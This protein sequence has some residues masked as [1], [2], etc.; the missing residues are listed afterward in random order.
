MAWKY[1]A[2]AWGAR[3]SI[4]TQA[5]DEL[6]GHVDALALTA[7]NAALELVADDGVLDVRQ[8]ESVERLH[9]LLAA[10]VEIKQ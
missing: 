10:W 1:H 4:S 9:D 6:E 2:I 8:V 3:N 5:T 7:A